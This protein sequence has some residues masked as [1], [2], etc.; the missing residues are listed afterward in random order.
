MSTIVLDSL[1]PFFFSSITGNAYFLY[2]YIY[3]RINTP[4]TRLILRVYKKDARFQT[5]LVGI[6][7]SPNGKKKQTN[8][9]MF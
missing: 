6:Y 4:S 9:L 8:L 2:Q 5:S 1:L 7:F 3:S